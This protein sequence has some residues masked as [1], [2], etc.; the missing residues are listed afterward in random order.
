MSLLSGAVRKAATQTPSWAQ[1]FRLMGGGTLGTGTTQRRVRA[2]SGTS[3]IYDLNSPGWRNIYTR[4]LGE[5]GYE[6]ITDTYGVGADASPYRPPA[7]DIPAIATPAPTSAPT[8]R[9]VSTTPVGTTGTTGTQ[10]NRGLFGLTGL[11]GEN[12][13][14]ATPFRFSGVRPEN[15]EVFHRT[16]GLMRP[17]LQR[18]QEALE[19]RLW[20]Q[21]V[22]PTSEYGR[23]R[24]GDLETQQ[25]NAMER[26]AL[27]AVG[28]DMTQQLQE[29][30]ADER[31]RQQLISEGLLKRTQPLNELLALSGRGGVQQPRFNPVPQ[32]SVAAPRVEQQDSIWNTVGQVAPHLGGLFGG[33]GS[34]GAGW[35]TGVPGASG[36]R[37]MDGRF[38]GGL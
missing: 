34:T 18:Q 5:G 28:A 13:P 14:R 29:R 17:H 10:A 36:S 20:N 22:G 25:H 38:V 30:S 8:T 26:L 11:Q 19:S 7:R 24:L 37:I 12:I 3:Q 6:D 31:L 15:T 9:A 4:Q 32:S 35:I 21:G 27:Q 1:N 2:P 33:A 23:D 16:L